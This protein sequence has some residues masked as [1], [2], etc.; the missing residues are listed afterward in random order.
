MTK[1]THEIRR[2]NLLKQLA[3]SKLSRAE[4]S[5]KAGVSRSYLSQVLS[6]GFRFGEKAARAL[7][8]SLR[9]PKGS[10]DIEGESS[11]APV[12]VWEKPDDLP[13]GTF[14]I[15]P[16]ISVRLSAGGGAIT[17]EEMDL[18]PL[19]FR[20]DWIRKKGVTSKGNLRIC[21]VT[22]DSMEDRLQEGDSVLIDTGQIEVMNNEVY[23]IRYGDE[24]RIKRLS[25][26]FDGGLLIRSDNPRYPEESLT[27]EQAQHITVI[28]RMLWRG[29]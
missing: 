11:L 17:G 2:E 27:P 12:S 7:E 6:E 23:A 3:K 1:T 8:I 9:L 4:F 28:G 24:L 20:D 29:G 5:R 22:G 14:A 25:K 21:E 15:V 16:R 18:P 19:A 13:E 26:R 10:L